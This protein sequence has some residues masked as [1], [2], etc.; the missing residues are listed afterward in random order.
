M[1]ACYSELFGVRSHISAYRTSERKL[2]PIR[3]VLDF[4]RA[5][6]WTWALRQFARLLPRDVIAC[7]LPLVAWLAKVR[8]APAEPLR[9]IAT[10][11]ALE[12]NEV[13]SVNFAFSSPNP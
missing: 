10:E 5:F 7:A 6:F 11:L 3:R 9:Y 1:V 2:L 4:E 13:C 8:I 12:L